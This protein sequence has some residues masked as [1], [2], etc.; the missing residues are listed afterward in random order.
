MTEEEKDLI[1]L[2]MAISPKLYVKELIKE[3]QE[4][5]KQLEDAEKAVST[6]FNGMITLKTQQKE[7]IKYLEDKIEVVENKI[8][9]LPITSNERNYLVNAGNDLIEILQKYKSTIGE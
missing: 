6:F 1:N 5:K 9:N 3:N 2:K 8:S 7:F 4:L